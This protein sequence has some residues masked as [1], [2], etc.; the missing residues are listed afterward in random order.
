MN[1][2][3]TILK[4]HVIMATFLEFFLWSTKE[5]CAWAQAQAQLS[6]GQG[7]ICDYGFYK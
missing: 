4:K 1:I 3:R 6:Q 5:M 2:S 7:R